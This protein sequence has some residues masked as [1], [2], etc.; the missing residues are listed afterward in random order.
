MRCSYVHRFAFVC[1]YEYRG[2]WRWLNALPSQQRY[3]RQKK[4]VKSN[5]EL[6]KRGKRLEGKGSRR[7]QGSFYSPFR[8]LY[9]FMLSRTLL[10]EVTV[11]AFRAFD[12]SALNMS[13]HACINLVAIL[14]R[15][16]IS[17]YRY[18]F[19]SSLREP[20]GKRS[21]LTKSRKRLC[22]KCEISISRH[23]MEDSPPL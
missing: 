21:V 9:S 7:G 23:S 19:A 18:S 10:F 22:K 2:A 8:S 11:K 3:N 6:A 4:G 14:A 13:F 5:K 20:T 16:A 1:K 12:W 15:E 17:L